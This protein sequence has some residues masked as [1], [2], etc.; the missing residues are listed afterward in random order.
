M[1][2]L[3]PILITVL[4]LTLQSCHKFDDS[5]LWEA[6][7]KNS[8]DIVE[9]QELC[10]QMN[11]DIKTLKTIV[12]AIEDADYITNISPLA[13]G[14]GYSITLNKYGTIIIQNGENGSNGKDG[15]NGQD[16]KDGRTPI[17]SVAKDA[18][19]I[20]YWTINGE[21]LTDNN[22]NK[23]KAVGED[24]E[25]G[26]DGRNGKDGVNGLN[27]TTPQFEIRED[28]WYVS[29]D[30]ETWEKLGKAS[31]NNGL[32]GE[33]GDAFF[34]GVTKGDGYVIFTLNDGNDT[35][36]KLPF[37]T[38]T[39]LSIN[40]ETAGGLKD[41]LTL[42]EQRS[43]TSLKI[44]GEV[45]NED[46]R[47]INVYLRSLEILDLSQATIKFNK[48]VIDQP[49]IN[50]FKATAVNR[51]LRHVTL[52]AY[53]I[54]GET[55]DFSINASYCLALETLTLTANHAHI[56]DENLSYAY[57]GA[58]I[59]VD[60]SP[61]LSKLII[62]EGV[63]ELKIDGEKSADAIYCVFPTVELPST[64][65]KVPYYLFGSYKK[66]D[67]ICH[68]VTPPDIYR[69]TDSQILTVFYDDDQMK[70][71]VLYVPSESVEKYK[72]TAGWSQ[73]GTILPI[74]E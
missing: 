15:Q 70:D 73:F 13:D 45:N 30:G 41:M 7:N 14:S 52:G 22:G 1:R 40:I 67:I 24:G 42:E 43:V 10:H 21:W 66:S 3:L 16:G 4:L 60:G 2:K 19:G 31:G 65:Q 56:D 35:Q 9:L 49:R 37:V 18:D 5:K 34:K 51:T 28:F 57:Y 32:N 36:L 55:A 25:D 6:I 48:P 47:F 20:Y 50:P 74:E 29:Y 12:A 72:S 58:E 62:A 11:S 68:A 26:E 27:G 33:D 54:D 38:D 61:C 59:S 44:S 69:G 71:M 63:T 23:I 17:I 53:M 8:Q 64:L 39:Q 46:I